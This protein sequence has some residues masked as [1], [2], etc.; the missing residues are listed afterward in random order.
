MVTDNSWCGVRIQQH[1]CII[2]Q[3]GCITCCKWESFQ[4][5]CVASGSGDGLK[6]LPVFLARVVAILIGQG[7]AFILAG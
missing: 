5:T 3:H 2:Q 7:A 4:M 1:G 6:I